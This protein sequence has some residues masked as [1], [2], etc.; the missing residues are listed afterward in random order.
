MPERPIIIVQAFT[1]AYL[2]V[3]QVPLKMGRFFN[4]FDKRDSLPV[5]VVNQSFVRKFFPD[6]NPIGKHVWIGRRTAPAQIVGVIG[7]IKNVSLSVDP[8]PE[9]D[10]PFTQLPWGRMNLIIRSAGDPKGLTA[11]ARLQIAKLDAD[12]APA[13]VRTF[14]E[15]LAEASARPRVLMYLLAGFA[16]FASIL[17]LVGLYGIISYS[18]AQRTQEMGVRIALGATRAD[19]L[20]LVLAYGA[21]VACVGIGIGMGCLL[22]VTGAMAKLVYGISTTDP[23]TFGLVPVV[24]LACALL[25]SYVPARRAMQVNVLDALRH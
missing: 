13:D 4:E 6:Q 11:A 19:L 2:R 3:L 10:L 1:P 9:F 7:D 16:G 5:I 18:V 21:M 14:D 17:A 8:Q 25:A 23:L 24:F 20:R 22:L 15:L 12:L